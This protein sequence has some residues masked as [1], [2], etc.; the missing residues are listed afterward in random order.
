MKI[1]KFLAGVLATLSI[2]ACSDIE[3]V[4]PESSTVLASQVVEI[5]SIKPERAKASFN[6]L[7]TH[8]GTPWKGKYEKPDDFQFLMMMFCNDLEGADAWI[9]DSGYNW[10]SVCGK[11]SSR[12]AN[13]RNP[14]IRY[15]TPYGLIA[16]VNIFLSGLD[17]ETQDPLIIN[18][19]AQARAL[20]A[21]AYLMQA[22]QFQFVTKKDA[23]CIPIVTEETTDFTNNPRATVQ[24]VY[25]L[26]FTDLNYAIEN[27]EGATRTSKMQ[28]DQNVAYGLRAR[29]NLDMQNYAEAATD[30]EKAAAGYTPAMITAPAFMSLS[31]TNWL[32]GFDCTSDMTVGDRAYSTPSSW[33]RSFSGNGYSPACAVYSCINNILYDKIPSTDVRKGW[34]V[35]EN[36]ESP[37]IKDLLWSN[38]QPVAIAD[39]GGDSKLPFIPYTNVKFG[40]LTIGTT[41]N[42]EDFPFMRVEEMILIQAEGYAKS[43]NE[44]KAKQILNDFVKTYR[45]PAYDCDATGL[46]LADEIWKQRRIELWGEGFGALDIKRLGKPLVRFHDDKSSF[47][48][49]FRFNLSNDDGWMLMRFPQGEMNTNFGIIDNSDG[50][51][52]SMGQNAELKDGVTD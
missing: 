15:Q 29:A 1:N 42:D 25:D 13:Y 8:L 35:D 45:D 14:Y 51:I 39:D 49:A 16:D 48:D 17:K 26:I 28:I 10:F 20:R 46:S 2:A 27:L 36:L 50:H 5:N 6:G 38:G 31:E 22:P 7:F 21:Y 47:P 43:G 41:T 34:W 23:P 40:C 9:P 33:L 18:M 11:L 3:N 12:N 30:A 44:G 52:P 24:Q 32:W 37:L 4:F 19:M